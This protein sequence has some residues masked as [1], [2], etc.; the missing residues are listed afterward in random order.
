MDLLDQI[1]QKACRLQNRIVLAEGTEL[2]TLK[3]AEIVLR[4]RLARIILLG[5]IQKITDLAKHE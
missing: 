3:A 1:K 4:E 5:D 2:R